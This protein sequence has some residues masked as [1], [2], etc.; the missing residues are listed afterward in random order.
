MAILK[1]AEGIDCSKLQYSPVIF[2]AWESTVKAH[3]LF[4]LID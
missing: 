3:N 4:V 2:E 1:T